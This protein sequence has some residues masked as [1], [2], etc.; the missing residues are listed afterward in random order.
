MVNGLYPIYK[1]LRAHYP[2]FGGRFIDDIDMQQKRRVAFLGNKVADAL[3]PGEKEPI[4]KTIFINNIPFLVV[5]VQQPKMQSSS[6]YNEDADKISIPASTY[7]AI[8][9]DPYVDNL[10]YAPHEEDQ[11]RMKE[12]EERFR[13]VVA[14][15]MKFDPTD[16]D[17]ISIWDV[18]ESQK[19]MGN[20]LIGLKYFMGFIG[21]MTLAIAGVGVANIM[22]VSVK[23]RTREIGIKM[24]MGARRATILWQFVTEA[25]FITFMGGALGMMLIYSL[26]EAFRRLPIKSD[27][28]D[29]MGRPRVS[30]IDGLI[31]IGILGIMGFLSGYFPARRAASLSP[32]ESLRY[33]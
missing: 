9:N 25:L 13:T 29:F 19:V 8:W 20:I 22:Y 24:A 32:V 21:F 1:T 26:T 31:I 5:G 23:E 12:F 18:V 6:Y 10:L 7:Q 4:G 3:M 28:L 11:G 15:K 16:K 17:A 27:V 2:Q 14:G 30:M 33:E